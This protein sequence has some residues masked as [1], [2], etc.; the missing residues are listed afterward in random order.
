MSTPSSDTLM[1]ADNCHQSDNTEHPA[2]DET[3]DH[4]SG[5]RPSSSTNEQT[6]AVQV[7]AAAPASYRKRSRI[8]ID[9]DD[10][11]GSTLSAS[12]LMHVRTVSATLRQL[13][14]FAMS[15]AVENGVQFG[16][17]KVSETIADDCALELHSNQGC[18]VD[19]NTEVA[20]TSQSQA[21]P[22]MGKYR[23]KNE[24]YAADLAHKKAG[25]VVRLERVRIVHYNI[26]LSGCSPFNK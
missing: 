26:V 22:F 24:R 25:D 20:G 8:D 3:N 6:P 16:E 9:G 18:V 17:E 5:G 12:Q 1:I 11:I 7:D 23:T 19:D 13:I 2:T 10:I 14:V 21:V 15:T 4:Y